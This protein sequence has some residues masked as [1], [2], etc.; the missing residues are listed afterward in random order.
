VEVEA[1]AVADAW[2]CTPRQLP[3]DR[4]VFLEWFRA[5]LLSERTKRRFD[6]AQANHSISRRGTLRGLHFADVPPGQ[7][8]YVYCARGAVVDIIVDVREGSPTFGA[9]V[10]VQLDDADRQGVFIAEGLAHA[11]CARSETAEVVY[12]VSSTYN[13][14]AEHAVNPLDPALAL[15][16]PSDVGALVLSDKDRAAPSLEQARAAGTLPSYDACRQRY[17]ELS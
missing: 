5:D 17:A 6:V 11:F 7:A 4:G 1:L 16:W 13:P 3:D 12:L 15:P 10:V 2:L 8:K 9:H 14:S